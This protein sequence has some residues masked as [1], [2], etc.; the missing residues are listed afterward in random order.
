[1][2]IEED[3]MTEPIFITSELTQK[4][5]ASTRAQVIQVCIA[6]H[7]EEDFQN[8]FS[9]VPFGG[10][11]FL[12]YHHDQVVS[13]AM[14]TT[15]WLQPDGHPVLKTAYIDAVA[16][17]PTF[18]GQ[19]YGSAVMR[20]LAEEI[21]QEYEIA[22]LETDRET[23]YERLGWQTW[24]GP[25]AGRGKDGLILTT[26]QPG[27]MILRL[28]QTPELDLDSMLTIECQTGRIW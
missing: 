25:L 8:L 14:V 20:H 23:F 10:W 21:D 1:M 28:S 9:Y 5:S 17:L 18:Q 16:T 13:H 11:H 26:E 2:P 15:R 12:A 4:L 27:I 24:R 7:Q 22:C 19:G 3:V 6:A